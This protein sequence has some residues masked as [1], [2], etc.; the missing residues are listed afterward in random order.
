MNGETIQE[1][2]EM[3][4]Q[5]KRVKRKQKMMLLLLFNTRT[6]L[7]ECPVSQYNDSLELLSRKHLLSEMVLLL[8][9]NRDMPF[10]GWTLVNPD[11]KWYF[12]RLDTYHT[13]HSLT[14]N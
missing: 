5:T 12:T 6:S 9:G 11:N 10:I 8:L 1:V 2:F 14:P 3:P 13:P 7:L 4:L